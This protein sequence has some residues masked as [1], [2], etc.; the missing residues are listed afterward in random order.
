MLSYFDLHRVNFRPLSTKE[1]RSVKRIACE[2]A[3]KMTS[4]SVV[5]YSELK[6]S[7]IF[8][9]GS[10]FGPLSKLALPRGKNDEACLAK[11]ECARYALSNIW[12]K[13][14]EEYEKTFVLS[15]VSMEHREQE[16]NMMK[17]CD[18]PGYLTRL[19]SEK[20]ELLGRLRAGGERKA[21]DNRKFLEGSLSSDF[22]S[23][24][25]GKASLRLNKPL[26]S[27]EKTRP[28]KTWESTKLSDEYAAA[29]AGLYDDES[30]GRDGGINSRGIAPPTVHNF[31]FKS[32]NA[33]VLRLLFPDHSQGIGEGS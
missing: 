33:K 26:K 10:S 20:R 14:Q 29:F 6:V 28:W 12:K 11:R 1:S 21:A 3:R 7:K 24:K 32:V 19:E 23:P 9:L 4:F 22:G 18:S 30:T 8:G 31:H 5:K 2:V 17:E 16:S 25:D 15:W 13:T 27:K